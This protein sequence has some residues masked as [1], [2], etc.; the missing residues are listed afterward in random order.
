MKFLISYP[1][2]KIVITQKFGENPQMYSLP[3]YGGI[4][5][6]NGI[7]YVA[8]IGTPIY[9]THDGMAYYEYDGN[10]GEGVVLR[11]NESFDDG[12]GGQ[13]FYKTIYWHMCDPVVHPEFTSPIYKA[14]GFKPDQTGVSN[15]SCNVQ[16]GNLIG[17]AD[18]TGA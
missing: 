6:H 16:N 15:T 8:P 17:Y 12:K 5:G 14:V 10:Q 9:A 11:T 13:C 3:Q 2:E 18:N 7:D 4:K 1:L